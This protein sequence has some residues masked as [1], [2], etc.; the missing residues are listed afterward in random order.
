MATRDTAK[1]SQEN[2]EIVKAQLRGFSGEGLDAFLAFFDDDI[3]Y[4]PVEEAETLRGFD[5]VRRYFESWVETWEEFR[6][7]PTEFL[8]SGACVIAGEALRGRGDLSG[9]EVAMEFW[10]VS[11]LRDGKV[12]RRDEYLD[13]NEALEAAGLSE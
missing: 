4:L 9:V 12:I 3:E 5:A 1:V 10:S 6:A 2:V 8:D 13:R 7:E 11:R